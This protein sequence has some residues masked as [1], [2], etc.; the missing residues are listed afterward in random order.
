MFG[1]QVVLSTAISVLMVA[2][3]T[4][5]L[6]ADVVADQSGAILIF[7]KIVVDTSAELNDDPTDTLLQITNTSNSV[8]SARCWL[9]DTT[10]RCIGVD[11]PETACTE[12]GEAEGDNR[13]STR[14]EPQ[15][16]VAADFQFTLTK[17]QPIAWR[18]S[19]GLL[20]FPCGGPVSDPNEP[21][22]C[23]FGSNTG[24]N[25][26]PSSIPL[27]TDDPF[28]GEIKCVQVNPDTELPTVGLNDGNDRGG[29]LAGHA[30]I[31]SVS[32]VD[33]RKYNAVALQSTGNQNLP[34]DDV[35]QIGGPNA[36]YNG[37]PHSLILQ[38]LFDGAEVP[39][40]NSDEAEVETE[41]TL[42][43]CSQDFRELT[44]P[45]TTLQLLV[46]NE[47][48]QRFSASTRF[49]CWKEVSLSDL[50]N[51]PGDADDD[52]SL[53]SVNVQGSLAGQTRIRPVSSNGRS[54]GVI[55]IAEEFWESEE[56]Q[57]SS[58]AFQ[59]NHVGVGELG[60]QII[61]SPI[62]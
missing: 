62:F 56:D 18:A 32:P 49:D 27:V 5:T 51:R 42:V 10:P 45:V 43:S 6:L 17:R 8:I 38:H 9:V 40:D 7:P 22:G 30:T 13:C 11:G 46:F 2:A 54:N 39:Y 55:G 61:L 31:V 14:C 1:R 12:A 20:N 21:S 53:F 44:T 16:E 58:S 29:D 57:E 47:F 60:D 35:L 4:N 3:F 24:P 28:F 48:E 52:F 41:V 59:F 25:G 15:W 50:V 37:C 19:E 33:A 23:A 34:V 36:E 26:L